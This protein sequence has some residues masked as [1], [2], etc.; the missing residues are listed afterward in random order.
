MTNVCCIHIVGIVF[1]EGIDEIPLK[2]VTMK[3]RMNSTFVHDTKLLK[4]PSVI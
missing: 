4:E 1:N 3:I 2:N